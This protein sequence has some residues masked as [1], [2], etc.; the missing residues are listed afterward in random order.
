[1][2]LN[3]SQEFFTSAFETRH[4]PSRRDYQSEKVVRTKDLDD[5]YTPRTK[6]NQRHIKWAENIEEV[7]TFRKHPSDKRVALLYKRFWKTS[8]KTGP[9]ILKKALWDFTDTEESETE[10]SST[11]CDSECSTPLISSLYTTSQIQKPGA[12]RSKNKDILSRSF[13]KKGNPIDAVFSRL[14]KRYKMAMEY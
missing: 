11:C 10:A 12:K 9:S 13:S 7:K 5:G 3:S 6:K 4:K 8:T 1:M 2:D 14:Y